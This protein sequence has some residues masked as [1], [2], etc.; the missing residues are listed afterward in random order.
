MG[1]HWVF[2]REISARPT[3][4]LIDEPTKG[5]DVGARS[6]IYQRLRDAAERGLAVVVS[7]SDGL[8][9]EGIC[10]R[11]LI[12]ARG[13]R[14]IRAPL[15]KYHEQPYF[16]RLAEIAPPKLSDRTMTAPP[17]DGERENAPDDQSEL[18]ANKT[19]VPSGAPQPVQLGLLHYAARERQGGSET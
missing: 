19:P 8:E 7:S 4:L 14:P 3:A 9:L 13:Q 2:G 10:D 17:A 11:V 1:G 5:V 6:E 15:L 18:V 12:F 16:E